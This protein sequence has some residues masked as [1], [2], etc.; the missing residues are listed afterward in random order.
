MAALYPDRFAGLVSWVG[1]TGDDTNGTPAQGTASVT[2]GAVGNMIDFVGN[3]RHVPA[4][5][6][7]A[8]RG[9]ARAARPPPRRWPTE[10]RKRDYPFEFFVHPAAEH[11]TFGPLDDWRKEAAYTKD[12]R[13]VRDPARVTFR[14]AAVLGNPEHGIRHDR[15]YWVSELRGRVARRPTTRGRGVLHRRRPAERWLRR[16][17]ASGD[18]DPGAGPD[19]VPWVAD[20]NVVTGMVAVAPE[21]RLTGTLANVA[22]LVVDVDADLPRGAGRGVRASPPTA[23][24]RCA[25][26]TAARSHS[27]EAGTVDRHAPRD[28]RWR[29]S[30]S[31]RPTTTASGPPSR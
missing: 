29:P 5:L 25:S 23:R 11:L 28:A 9:R 31:A 19:P 15:A 12:L 6:I 14:T 13:R 1:F 17:G 8:R 24:A 18:A 26:A 16:G 3:Y 4:A 7:Y 20:S 22:S 21:P 27:P 10:Y 2:A 30:R